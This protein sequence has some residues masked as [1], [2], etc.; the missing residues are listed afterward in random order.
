MRVTY[1]VVPLHPGLRAAHGFNHRGDVA[2][3]AAIAG[4]GTRAVIIQDGQVR[5]IGTLG[6]SFSS[7]RGINGRGDVVGGALTPGDHE[8]HG[9]IYSDGQLMDLN[10]LLADSRWEVVEAL[11]IRDDGTVLAIGS[12]DGVDRVVLLV[13][14]VPPG[15]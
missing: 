6:G 7:A 12:K 11:D 9:F 8:H 4:A 2:G 13:P 3:D 5:V 1:E 14:A 10:D 15:T